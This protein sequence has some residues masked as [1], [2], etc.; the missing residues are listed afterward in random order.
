[1]AG[2]SFA[3]NVVTLMAGTGLAQVVPIL[4]AP[5]L[6]RM[7]TPEEFGVFALYT[8]I[9]AVLAVLVA[10]K[11]ELA[12][13]I[14]K[15]EGEAINLVAISMALSAVISISALVVVLG[16]DMW[17]VESLEIGVG[18]IYLIP[19]TTFLMGSYYA[20]NYW[21]N[22]K[23]RYK[24]MSASRVGQSL[25]AGAVQLVSGFG[26]LGS[27][28]LI[29]G[30]II[31]QATS[32]IYLV[33]ASHKLDRHVWKKVSRKRMKYVARRYI[34]YP[35]YMVPGQLLSV[36]ANEMPLILITMFYG[37]G[38]AGIYSLAQRITVAPLSL[39][40]GAV[41]DVYRQKA[42]ESYAVYG[43]CRDVF[44][45]TLKKL[46]FFALVVVFPILLF[47]PTV[48][49]VLF[50]AKWRAAGEIA[51]ILSILLFFQTVS[52][53]L[54]TTILLAGWLKL[55]SVW[56]LARLS[57]TVVSFYICYRTGLAYEVAIA[58]H[59]FVFC[60]LYMLHSYFQF[61]AANGLSE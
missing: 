53:P 27:G 45:Q 29:L 26:K 30:Q 18:W 21:T 42:S 25:S 28:G 17:S 51:S 16:F 56:Q 35:K 48:F 19:I 6:T 33:W 1:M 58:L 14:A 49:E 50:G 31:G 34:D 7:F 11:Y 54:S 52:S 13:V 2:G 60:I 43:E 12:V 44:L 46:I 4:I 61:L 5:V 10:G 32:F 37:P 47:G 23:S 15:H 38:I 41:G 36:G 40:A 20:I 9:C 24:S 3:K 55:E 59:V 22:R 39:L 8:S 57:A